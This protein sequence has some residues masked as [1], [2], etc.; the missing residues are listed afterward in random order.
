M[1]RPGRRCL[2]STF[3]LSFTP[4]FRSLS[5]KGFLCA[6][7][8]NLC[9][10]VVE[11]LRKNQPQRNR[12][13]T[14]KHRVYFSDRLLKRGVNERRPLKSLSSKSKRAIRN[15]CPFSCASSLAN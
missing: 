1:I 7:L 2:K 14:E 8:W 6:T 4:G 11:L 5:E 13:R 12:D 10:S 15:D 3:S 9:A